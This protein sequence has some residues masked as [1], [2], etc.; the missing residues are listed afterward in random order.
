MVERALEIQHRSSIDDQADAKVETCAHV[1]ALRETTIDV[2][3][4]LVELGSRTRALRTN[5]HLALCR[6]LAA[7]GSESTVQL[8][9]STDAMPEPLFSPQTGECRPLWTQCYWHRRSASRIKLARSASA[10]TWA[11][12]DSTA[13]L[14]IA[15]G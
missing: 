9:R 5:E 7:R 15:R 2:D 14:A 3:T 12:A 11:L 10:P 13:A 4:A 6:Y 1:G 8:S